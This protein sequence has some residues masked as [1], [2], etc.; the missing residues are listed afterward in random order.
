MHENFVMLLYSRLWR[1]NGD[2]M[3]NNKIF[4]AL[5]VII[6]MAAVMLLAASCGEET[7]TPDDPPTSNNP[8]TYTVS[9]K[10]YYGN[11]PTGFVAVELYKG[12]E[13]VVQTRMNSEGVATFTQPAGDYTFKIVFPDGQYSYDESVAVFN[14]DTTSVDVTLYNSLGAS[15]TIAIPCNEHTDADKDGNCDYCE[16]PTDWMFDGRIQYKA[17]SISEGA[18]IVTIDRAKMSYFIFTPTRG[19]IFK[20]S[21][22]VEG[23]A[24]FGNFGSPHFIQPNTV[25]DV[26]DG[27]FIY[28]IPDSSISTG[29]GGTMQMVIG[30]GSEIAKTAIIKI[31]RIGNYV[32]EMP[33]E[34]IMPSPSMT[35]YDSV[36]NNELVDI[37]ITDPSVTVVY[38][39]DDGFFHYGSADGPIVLVKIST[40]G[41]SHLT[42][43]TLTSF[44]EICTTDRMCKY[45]YDE[46]GELIAKKSY[47]Y[48]IEQYAALT[49][50]K[51]VLPLDTRMAEAI[52]NT[53][54]QNGWWGSSSTIFSAADAMNIVAEN[55]YLFACCYEV[56]DVYGS[57]DKPI[58]ITPVAEA[59][60]VELAVAADAD[61]TTVKITVSA[62]NLTIENAAGVTVTVDGSAYTAGDDGVITITVQK[63]SVFT[64]TSESG[65]T[66]YIT[67]VTA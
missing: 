65:A 34:D 13:R 36:L 2:Y 5:L 29:D 23:N 63:D 30:I 62:A 17:V 60:A 58:V 42:D 47:N 43:F 61:G 15:Q 33:F 46:N 4:I 48:L 35:K 21:Y 45:F 16:Y 10:D 53:G 8:I 14:S 24:V 44:V 6:M 54:D 57:A 52:K 20:F 28:T 49:G 26:I 18:S 55:A 1:Q 11:V 38:N 12:E 67:C 64:V 7:P 32:P 37:D 50:S 25:S 3:K 9:M 22:A 59:D 40:A 31:E 41:N 66:V 27:E 51:G 56:E 19:G 39:K